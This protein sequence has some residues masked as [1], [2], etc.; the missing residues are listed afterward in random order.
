MRTF[1]SSIFGCLLVSLVAC[2]IE[3]GQA[4]GQG[5]GSASAAGGMANGSGAGGAPTSGGTSA[6]GE[7]SSSAV[8]TDPKALAE[9][10]EARKTALTLGL[11]K[12]RRLTR[13]QLDNTLFD[14]LGVTSAPAQALAP[15]E[16][17]GPFDNN[18][19]TPITD[20]LVQQHQEIA[21][22]V[23]AEVV[24]NR[25][26]VMGCDVDAEGSPCASTFI[27]TFGKRALRRPLSAEESAAFLS[28]YE[29]GALGESPA[30]GFQLLVEAFLQSPSFLYHIDVPQSGTST[31]AAEP[32]D[33]FVLASRLSYFLWN[34]MPD[35]ALFAAAS[36]GSLI[37]SEGIELQVKRLLSDDRAAETIGLFHR[38]W[39]KVE[40][41]EAKAKDENVY[42]GFTPEIAQAMTRE[43]NRFSDYVIR[44]GDGLLSTLLTANFTFPEAALLPY[45]GIEAP[46]GFSDGDLV[47]IP[48][49]R[50]GILTLP[51]VMTKLSHAN[52]TSPVHRGILVRENLLCQHVPPPP[53]GVSTALP[54]VTTATTTRQRVE[55]HT[56]SAACAG[57]HL[58]IDPLGMAF[59]NYDGVG[60]YR[61]EDG[62]GMVD[63]HGTFVGT[64]DDLVGEFQD[65]SD[66]AAQLAAASEVQD[67]VS[68][69]WFRFALGRAE[70]LDD[71]CVLVELHEGFRASGANINTLLYLIA[72]SDALR[73]VRSTAGE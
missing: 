47:E 67:C 62:T 33:S 26:Q 35:E 49:P 64:R 6:G 17:I 28:L 37:T 19:S 36:D 56:A 32:A 61:T 8:P 23:A 27:E 29:L 48:H 1:V 57:C 63:P 25:T 16:K 10:C 45:Y 72:T 46:L 66:M 12:L 43:F 9:A 71:A 7:G 65:A 4:P 39:L 38:Q 58:L 15:D 55:Q 2:S 52:Q 22:D 73:N 69:Q 3:G 60:A 18:S 31:A 40:G 53:P 54:E 68:H 30:H 21:R 51:A 11:T 44:A 50:A 70:S 24:A 41:I 14:L 20:L 34:T 13:R 59:E 5:E 42:P